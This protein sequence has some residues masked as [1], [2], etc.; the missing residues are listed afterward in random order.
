[1]GDGAISQKELIL[2]IEE[3]AF[4]FQIVRAWDLDEEAM[5]SQSEEFFLHGGDQF[6]VPGNFISRSPGE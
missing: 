6:S 3:I 4:G 5:V 1:M 2:V